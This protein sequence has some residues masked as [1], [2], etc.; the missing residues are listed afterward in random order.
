MIAFFGPN[1]DVAILTPDDVQRYKQARM[2]GM[3]NGRVVGVRS[4]AADIVA[5]QTMLNWGTRERSGNGGALLGRNPLH[6][7]KLPTEKNPQ[8]PIETFDRF[9]KLMEVAESVDWRLPLALTLAESTGR[10]VSAI[11]KLQVSDVDLNREPFGWLKFRSENDKIGKEQHVPITEFARSVLIRHLERVPEGWLFPAERNARKS[12]DT[13]VMSRALRE[14]YQA[15]G[16][17]TLA[18]GLWHPWR[19]KWASERKDLPVVDVAAAGGWSNPATMLGSYQRPDEATTLRVMLAA[20]K[21]NGAGS[22]TPNVTPHI[23]KD[24]VN[25]SAEGPLL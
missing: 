5:L 13:S 21:R 19:R 2:R 25:G 9:Q 15:A 24:R 1:L 23:K 12:V 4:V 22:L 10:R 6:G 14:A 8:R 7:V 20:P 11:L 16:L 17:E 18:G 3:V